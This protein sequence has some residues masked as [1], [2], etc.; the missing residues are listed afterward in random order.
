[1]DK[2]ADR[3]N[4]RNRKKSRTRNRSTAA[5]RSI[6]RI[7]L[8]LC[9]VFARAQPQIPIEVDRRPL[10]QTQVEDCYRWMDTLG[11][12]EIKNGPFVEF[13]ELA[14]NRRYGPSHGFLISSNGDRFVVRQLDW[15]LVGFPHSIFTQHIDGAFQL[16]S[17]ENWVGQYLN[18]KSDVLRERPPV[19]IV[20]AKAFWDR[21][22]KDLAARIIRRISTDP[23]GN[24]RSGSFFLAQ[25]QER[26]A[27][28]AYGELVN[29]FMDTKCSRTH[30]LAKSE[31]DLSRYQHYPEFL[32]R[33]SVYWGE[34]SKMAAV[35]TGMISED[36]A[37]HPKPFV[38][39]SRKE[40]IADAIFRLRDQGQWLFT[41]YSKGPDP[42]SP[43]AFLKS[44]GMAAVPQLIE[45]LDDKRFTRATTAGQS[46]FS[47][48]PKLYTFGDVARALL[49]GLT[50]RDF[51]FVRFRDLDQL[52]R[53]AHHEKDRFRKWFDDMQS[54]GEKQVLIEGTASGDHEALG[55]AELLVQKYPEG[56]AAALRQGIRNAEN[57]ET[58][59]EFRSLLVKLKCPPKRT[60][61][62]E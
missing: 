1:M 60:K 29:M 61:T 39:M 19:M 28:L 6:P 14:R 45:T 37:Y 15:E 43:Y 18:T 13:W 24:I 27:E 35:L 38:R 53:D 47:S 30:I 46:G 9:L 40:R 16:V 62:H 2:N 52:E 55:Q 11:Y 4:Y 20:L 51:Y 50:H 32:G 49:V 10:T 3:V 12:P 31:E 17:L 58:A 59:E 56:A 36:E 41:A 42:K 25:A 57:E 48:G 33:H 26:L 44:Q 21:G 8:L 23:N 34:M 7:D 54:K 5:L 22:L